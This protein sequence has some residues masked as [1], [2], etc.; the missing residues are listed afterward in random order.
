[1]NFTYKYHG[2]IHHTIPRALQSKINTKLFYPNKK[3]KIKFMCVHVN[4][5]DNTQKKI[6]KF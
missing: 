6:K 1:M 5:L 4:S 3:I 2:R